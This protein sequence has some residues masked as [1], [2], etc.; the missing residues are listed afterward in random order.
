MV[1]R[2]QFT[3]LLKRLEKIF[4]KVKPETIIINGDIK[5]EFGTISTQEWRH[6]L[7][8]IDF[9]ARNCK[10]LILIKGN[11]DKIL[12]PIAE[13][14]KI[15]IADNIVLGDILITHGHKRIK[16]LKGIKTIIIGHEHPAVSFAERPTEK[17]KCFLKGTHK[18]KTLIVMPSF[19]LVIEGSDITKEK[20]LSPF[21]TDISNFEVYIAEDKIYKFGK[22]KNL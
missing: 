15:T 5:H 14:R 9:L 18:R 21:L 17:F 22:V 16:E 1:P 6:T 13:K 8:L 20:L 2:F 3:E 7:R 10:K 4:A 12:G 11:H 19:N